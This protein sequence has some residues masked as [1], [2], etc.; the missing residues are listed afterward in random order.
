MGR[1]SWRRR[2]RMRRRIR[3][4]RRRGRRRRRRRR[5]RR[6][7]RTR[8]TKEDEEEDE[9]EEEE[10]EEDIT[11]MTIG[12]AHKRLREMKLV[13]TFSIVLLLISLS[14]NLIFVYSYIASEHLECNRNVR[15][16]PQ[17]PKF[18][19]QYFVNIT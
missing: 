13:K 9:E 6:R 19:K 7:T 16:L 10:E 2:S 5:T 17:L 8:R 1:K 11:I 15:H 18:N 4:G 12:E 14:V 3:M